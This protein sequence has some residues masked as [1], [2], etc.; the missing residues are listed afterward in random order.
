MD[1]HNISSLAYYSNGMSSINTN[2]RRFSTTLACSGG[3]RVGTRLNRDSFTDLG[4]C[5]LYSYVSGKNMRR[6]LF[7]ARTGSDTIMSH[8]SSE[9]L[10][11]VVGLRVV[12]SDGNFDYPRST[13]HSHNDHRHELW[14]ATREKF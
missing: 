8:S 1:H 12:Q 7:D 5:K 11:F 10:C 4:T 6:S 3:V 2:E 9:S 14:L 13:A